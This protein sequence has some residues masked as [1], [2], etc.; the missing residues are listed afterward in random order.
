[1]HHSQER[2]V[3]DLS[4]WLVASLI[5]FAAGAVRGLTGFGFAAF[6]IVGLVFLFP[7]AQAVPLVLVL[8][9][10]ACV[11]LVPR[12]WARVEWRLARPLLLAS[13]AGVPLGLTLLAHADPAVLTLAVYALICLLAILGL[14]RLPLPG[15][16]RPGAAW[17]VGGATGALIAAFSIG[18][19]LVAAWLAST[20]READRLRATL[21][22]F[23]GAVD[24]AA[25]LAIAASGKL[26]AGTASL[27][28][29]L[30]PATLAGLVAGQVL[31][32]RI[33]PARAVAATQ[34]LL[35]SLALAGLYVTL[36]PSGTPA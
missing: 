20:C 23:F 15:L 35:L 5:V 13:L 34:W 10:A 12:A 33:P 3:P 6:S 30:L 21:I 2:T 18:G 19:P 24:V 26:A 11:L 29:A 31:F 8:E 16:A 4:T 36:Q 28:A 25:V 7:L 17:A 1:M 9:I 32:H 22:V 14:L 27:A